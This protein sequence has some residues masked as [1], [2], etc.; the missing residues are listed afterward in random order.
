[1]KLD[2]ENTTSRVKIGEEELTY[3]EAVATYGVRGFPTTLF[4]QPDGQ[5]IYALSG[6]RPKDEYMEI[7]KYIG[8]RKFED[9]EQEEGE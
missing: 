8:E 3:A 7:L 9:T 2:A 5:L 6:Y 4:L 1:M